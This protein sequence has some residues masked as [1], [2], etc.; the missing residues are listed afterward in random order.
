MIPPMKTVVKDLKTMVLLIYQPTQTLKT[1]MTQEEVVAAP[2]VVL[3]FKAIMIN[4]V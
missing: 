4:E 2:K 3:E 1:L